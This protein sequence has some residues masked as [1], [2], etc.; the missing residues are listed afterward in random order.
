MIDEFW[1]RHC[2]VFIY[3]I[4]RFVLPI[5]RNFIH[6]DWFEDI[7]FHGKLWFFLM[8]SRLLSGYLATNWT[9][10]RLRVEEFVFHNPTFPLTLTRCLPLIIDGK[11]T[12]HILIIIP[13]ILTTRNPFWTTGDTFIL[14]VLTVHNKFTIFQLSLGL[15][16]SILLVGRWV[17][18]IILGF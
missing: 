9:I 11:R 4:R 5:I 12:L 15:V 17:I 3:I 13:I 8:R 7:I 10:I 16:I 2:R 18:E 6:Y 1:F 14:K